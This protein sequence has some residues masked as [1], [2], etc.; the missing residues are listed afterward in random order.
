MY[1]FLPGHK[2][3]AKNAMQTNLSC[4]SFTFYSV[5]TEIWKEVKEKCD[6]FIFKNVLTRGKWK[7][8][9]FQTTYTFFG[10]S[11]RKFRETPTASESGLFL[12]VLSHVLSLVRLGTAVITCHWITCVLMTQQWWQPTPTCT[13]HTK[14]TNKVEKTVLPG[15]I[16]S[17]RKKQIQQ[18]GTVLTDRLTNTYC[19][20]H[21]I[22]RLELST[23]Y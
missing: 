19:R 20:L 8:A 11:Q 6:V 21:T 18:R 9:Y 1:L 23:S 2:T 13:L 7:K 4:G 17:Y 3:N 16:A 12:T 14:W 10:C 15:T 5:C 22:D